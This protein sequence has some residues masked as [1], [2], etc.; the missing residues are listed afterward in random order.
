MNKPSYAISAILLVT[1]VLAGCG[2]D[3]SRAPATLVQ[4]STDV[5]ARTAAPTST[6]TPVS[7]TGTPSPTLKSVPNSADLPY[8]AA[9][10][11]IPEGALARIGMGDIVDVQV[12]PNGEQAIIATT[13]GLYAYQLPSF[14]LIW[15]QIAEAAPESISLAPDG[16]RLVTNHAWDEPPRLYDTQ[17]GELLASLDGWRDVSWSPDSRRIASAIWPSSFRENAVGTVSHADVPIHI[18]DGLTGQ[19][20]HTFVASDNDWFCRYDHPRFYPVAQRQIPRCVRQ[21]NCR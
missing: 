21:P 8:P 11:A 16:S 2:I 10:V 14:D 13:T 9:D 7:P 4:T 3:A 6:D 15:R 17:T 12:F 5:P 20:Q 19:L 18:Y 1:L